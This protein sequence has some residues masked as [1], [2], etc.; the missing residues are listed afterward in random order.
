M[1]QLTRLNNETFTLNAL[2][3]EKIQSHP[4]TI[5]TLMNGKTFVVKETEIHVTELI[6]AYYQKIGLQGWIKEAGEVNE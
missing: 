5:I 6:T 3:I 1:I 2:M 4:D